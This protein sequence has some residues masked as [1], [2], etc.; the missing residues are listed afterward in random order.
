MDVVVVVLFLI[1]SLCR[2][3]T[4]A[5]M[6]ISGSDFN[7]PPLERSASTPTSVHR[8]RPSDIDLVGG[9]GDSLT[10]G[11]GVLG[12]NVTTIYQVQID[13]RGVAWSSGLALI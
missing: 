6:N 9:M 3:L 7:C 10:A 5:Q 2:S 4:V 11:F 1:S 13:Y 12:Y 8:L